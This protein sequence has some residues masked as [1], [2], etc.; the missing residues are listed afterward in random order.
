MD[1]GSGAA[2]WIA[3]LALF[4]EEFLSNGPVTSRQGILSGGER[5][6]AAVPGKAAENLLL[7]A[8]RHEGE[9]KMPSRGDQLGEAQIAAFERWINRGMA[10]PANEKVLARAKPFTMSDAER[11]HWAFKPLPPSDAKWSVVT[12]LK[13][14]HERLGVK[15][16]DEADRHRLLRRVT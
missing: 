2:T 15:A 8:I 14:H 11:N 5:G 3:L 10:W 1:P 7:R 16:S 13:P 6:P 9:L 4:A 12:A